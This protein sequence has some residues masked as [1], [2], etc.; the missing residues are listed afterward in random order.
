MNDWF[1]NIKVDR[2]ERPDLDNVYMLATQLI[3]AG[4]GGWP[5]NLFLTP[6]LAPFYAGGYFPPED[7]DF[8]RP[9]FPTILKSHPR[10]MGTAARARCA[11]APRAFV[12]VLRQYQ[13]K[14]NGRSH[15]LRRIRPR[16]SSRA[17]TAILKRFDAEHGG[18]SSG[19]QATKFPQS[20]VLE[21]MLFD[22]RINRKPETL[23]FLTV[24]LDAMAYGGIYDQLGGG[25][26][27]YSTERTW[28]IPHFEKML[29]DNAQLLV[30]LH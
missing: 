30:D 19:R 9:G 2:E 26:H 1:V 17:R 7:D 4:A 29:Y 10:G 11:A 6:E 27:R 24:T 15:E 21:L 25:F 12:T 22:Y 14:A 20:P 3:T 16:G 13:E 18:L 28:S 23:R 8:G 5:N